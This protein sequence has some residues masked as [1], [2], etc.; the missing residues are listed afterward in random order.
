M[1]VRRAVYGV[2]VSA[3]LLLGLEAGFRASGVA[4]PAPAPSPFGSHWDIEPRL[5]DFGTGMYRWCVGAFDQQCRI[6]PAGLRVIVVGGSAAL[7]LPFSPRTSF[8]S[9]LER[10]LLKLS[11]GQPVEVLNLAFP[12]HSSRQERWRLYYDLA[13]LRADLL[14]IASGNNEF[15]E[16]RAHHA[17]DPNRD[18]RTTLVAE[19]L[20]D[21]SMFRFLR[22]ALAGPPASLSA[23]SEGTTS[24]GANARD[25]DRQVALTLYRR[26]LKAMITIAREAGTAVLLSTVADNQLYPPYFSTGVPVGPPGSPPGGGVVEPAETTAYQRFQEGGRALDAGDL[27]GARALLEEAEYLD[28]RP[29][30]ASWALREAV[31]E[32]GREDDVA[33]C[34]VARAVAERSARGVPGS[35]EFADWCHPNATG[36]RLIAETLARCIVDSKLLPLSDAARWDEVLAS[37]P[38]VEVDP[39]RVDR[40]PGMTRS[41][42]VDCPPVDDAGLRLTCQGHKAFGTGNSRAP[43]DAGALYA[44]A[45]EA[46]APRA[47]TLINIGYAHL[48]GG[49]PE[50]AAAAFLEASALRGGDPEL[51]NLAR[52]QQPERILPPAGPGRGPPPQGGGRPGPPAA[53]RALPPPV[54]TPR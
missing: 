36:H 13:A 5:Q 22:S 53:G 17:L 41:T 49:R 1:K 9:Q 52:S 51:L 27:P 34:D 30:R 26:N 42:Q 7:G 8:A 21:L 54:A 44:R 19:V 12:G 37:N 3:G 20:N 40:I 47:A 16:L 45:L 46:G 23:G 25:A 14:V 2:L 35:A 28:P 10:L 39:Y 43:D 48:H 33:T 38:L 15:W 32:V 29:R 31:L 50:Q 11:G 6:E 18:P 24:I 4:P